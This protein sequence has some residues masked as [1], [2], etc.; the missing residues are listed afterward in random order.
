[1]TLLSLCMTVCSDPGFVKT[2]NVDFLSLLEVSDSHQLCPDCLTVR[3]ARS[4]H[5]SVCNRC[6]ER[7]DHHCPWI[8]NCVGVKNHTSFYIFVVSMLITLAL[9]LSQAVY[10][11]VL[12]LQK[13]YHQVNFWDAY[14][15]IPAYAFFIMVSLQIIV[16]TFFFFPVMW[17]SCVQTGNILTNKT[18]IERYSRSQP[19]PDDQQLRLIN[20]GIRNDKRVIIDSYREQNLSFSQN[21][22]Q[23][24][25]MERKLLTNDMRETNTKDLNAD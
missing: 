23:D 19:S 6:V 9:S 16:S 13:G 7:F 8:N 22:R 25:E 24:I 10:C 2:E 21:M 5:C 17:L 3:T 20:S 15:T 4:R 11:L 18:T 1:M 14:Y 12:V